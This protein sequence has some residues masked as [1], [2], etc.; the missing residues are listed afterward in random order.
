M[1]QE[2]FKKLN[3]SS[4]NKYNIPKEIIINGFNDNNENDNE[5]SK[6]YKLNFFGIKKNLIDNNYKK[7]KKKK[8]LD[9]FHMII[10]KTYSQSISNSRNKTFHS[11]SKNSS[12]PKLLEKI[13][14]NINNNNEKF[15][16]IK[17][18]SFINLKKSNFAFLKKEEKKENKLYL[19][20]IFPI[21]KD[22]SLPRSFSS[23]SFF[24]SNSNR[25]KRIKNTYKKIL[26]SKTIDLDLNNKK[27]YQDLKAE[28]FKINKIKES[29]ETKFRFSNFKLE[30]YQSENDIINSLSNKKKIKY[31][32][33][34]PSLV[35]F[36]KS[37]F[38]KNNVIYMNDI[39]NFNQ[40]VKSLNEN[41]KKIQKITNLV[42]KI[43]FRSRAS[44]IKDKK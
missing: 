29:F 31:P 28:K 37:E 36:V 27:I 39:N 14:L 40:E 9:A 42:S 19:S 43:I 35:K 3:S 30:K 22:N 15:I 17:K 23:S 8:N 38:E 12:T 18:R 34:T 2:Q 16:R 26:A 6:T 33:D 10:P 44:E 24:S 4:S 20:E 13:K 21:V 25:I 41:K 1:A 5:I 11:K 7:S 32:V